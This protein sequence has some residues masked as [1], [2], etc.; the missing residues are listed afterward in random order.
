MNISKAPKTP[1]RVSTT[2][3]AKAPKSQPAPS[4]VQRIVEGTVDKTLAGTDRMS[5][6]LS[7][8]V[9]GTGAYLSKLPNAI[10]DATK[11]IG[12]LIKAETIGPN[13]KVV[14]G[15]ASPVLLGVA[16]VG[17]GLGLVISAGAGAVTGFTAHDADKPR[18]FTIGEA[19]GNAWGNVRKSMDEMG[20]SAIEGSQE[21]RDQKLAEGE[22][23]WDIPLPPFGRTAK[24]MAATVAGIAIGGV[25]GIATAIATTARGAWDG[26]KHTATNLTSPADALAGLGAVVASPVT[27]ILEG[28][29]KVLTTP[30]ESAAVAWKEKTL[31]GA[32]KAAGKEAFASEGGAFSSAVGAFVGGATVAVPS[33]V[34]AGG[35]TTLT[36]LGKGLKLAATDKDLNLAG[37]LLTGAGSVVSAPVAGAFHGVTTAVGTPFVAVVSAKNEKSLVGGMATGLKETVKGTKTISNA[38]GAVAGGVLIGATTSVATTAAATLTQVVGG[39]TEAATN[40]DLNLTGKLLDGAGG[41]AGDVVTA[42]GQGVGNLV[43]APAKAAGAAFESGSAADGIKSAAQFGVK[44]VEAGARPGKTLVELVQEPV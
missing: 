4:D 29:S 40:E 19:V 35:S 28:A 27:G 31:G 17:A 23:P 11:S 20:D 8:L 26:I 33:A 9:A 7:G 22:D 15:L 14:A 24:T 2:A 38:A 39:L 18:D 36:T 13:I 10:G 43:M 42:I 41:L 25:G 44:S 16:A 12:N 34:V 21:I 32:L 30:V 3:A 1:V 37:K 6:S 5:G